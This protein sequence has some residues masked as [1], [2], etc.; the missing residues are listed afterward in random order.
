MQSDGSID[1]SIADRMP[2][3][4]DAGSTADRMPVIA[5]FIVDGLRVVSSHVPAVGRHPN[6]TFKYDI[7]LFPHGDSPRHPA[8]Q[9]LINRLLFA[10]FPRPFLTIE[11]SQTNGRRDQACR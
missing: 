5:G 2:D 7:E 4:S 1:G 10:G 9:H 11:M 8:V 3:I 6:G